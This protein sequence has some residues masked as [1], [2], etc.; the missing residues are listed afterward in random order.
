MKFSVI[1]NLTTFDEHLGP[2]F[3]ILMPTLFQGDIFQGL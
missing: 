2:V 3:S 1:F